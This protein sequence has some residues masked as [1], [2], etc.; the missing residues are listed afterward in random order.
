MKESLL[1]VF[2][3]LFDNWL[4][5]GGKATGSKRHLKREL[6]DVGFEEEE[7][8]Q[9]LNWLSA[10]EVQQQAGNEQALQKSKAFRQYLPEE[11]RRISTKARGF[12]LSLEQSNI[13]DVSIR[14]NI[15]ERLMDLD[16]PRV[17]P[18]QCKW[19]TAM[20]MFSS[21]GE[22]PNQIEELLFYEHRE[23]VMH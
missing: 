15:I 16:V 14:E 20:V 4:V 23:E 6:E 21:K 9:A 11:L 7:I 2:M 13:I 17:S 18:A 10:I 22:P 8:E 19:V 3:Y 5:P 1:D 12:L